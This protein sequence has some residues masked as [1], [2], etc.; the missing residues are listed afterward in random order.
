VPGPGYEGNLVEDNEGPGIFHE[1][2]YDAEIRINEV[3]GNGDDDTW[4]WGS[5]ILAA[6]S[7]TVRRLHSVALP[8]RSDQAT[9]SQG[10]GTN[11]RFRGFEACLRGIVAANYAG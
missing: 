3:S 5:Q 6:A 8:Y 7:S 1:I 4:V 11:G 9:R 10:L 2:S